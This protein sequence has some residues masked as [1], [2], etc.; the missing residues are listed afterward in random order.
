VHL[1]H[2]IKQIVSAATAPLACGLAIAIAGAIFRFFGLRRVSTIFWV[3]AASVVYFSAITPVAN[4]LLAPLEGRYPPLTDIQK[5][6]PVRYVVVL[7]SAYAPREGIPI[8]AALEGDGLA[9]IAEG[10]RLLRQIPGARLVVSGGAYGQHTASAIGYSRFAVDFGVDPASI[11]SLDK[12]LDTEEE[13]ASVAAL[14]GQEP[15]ILVTS[16]YHMPRAVR[17]MQRAGAHPIPAPTGQI[18]PTHMDFGAL[19]WIPRSSSL[20]KTERAL[21]EYL[22]L[23]IVK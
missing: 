21:H 19:G 22:G 3:A 15:F 12:S 17:L 13:A 20:L 16:A 6:P 23:A 1:W 7:G 8:T 2:F 9:R 11:V 18:T 14:V 10:V 4:A 5:L